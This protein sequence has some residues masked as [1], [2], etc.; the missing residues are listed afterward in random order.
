LFQR[1]NARDTAAVKREFLLFV[2]FAWIVLT[3]R[4]D[5]DTQAWSQ[6]Q[7]GLQARLFIS[8]A[9]SAD[10]AYG[11]SIEFYNV[12]ENSSAVGVDMPLNFSRDDL[13]VTVRDAAGNIIKPSPPQILDEPVPGWSW[14]LPAYGRISFP[15]ARGGGTPL[16]EQGQGKLLTFGGQQQWVLPPTGG[17][18]RV[19]AT[20]YSDFRQ[21]LQAQAQAEGRT[22]PAQPPNVAP[23]AQRRHELRGGWQGTLD[24]PPLDLP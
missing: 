4:A 17:P 21:A 1:D 5:D 8:P 9:R 2:L 16:H 12:L 19:S 10:Y 6:V 15:I 3:L 18:F 23:P 11:I 13:V 22:L 14:R 7:S 20:L 24:L